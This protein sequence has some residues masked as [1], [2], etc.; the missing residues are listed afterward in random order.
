MSKVMLVSSTTVIVHAGGPIWLN[1]FSTV[2]LNECNVFAVEL[3]L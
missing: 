2:L 3:C 1:P